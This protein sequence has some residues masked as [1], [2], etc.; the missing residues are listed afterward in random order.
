LIAAPR[1]QLALLSCCIVL[2]AACSS[3]PRTPTSDTGR[4]SPLPASSERDGPPLNP[5]ADIALTPDA[6]PQI[7]PIRA[8]GPNKPYEVQGERYTPLTEDKPITQSGLASWYGR[9]FHGRPTA[10][11]ELYSMYA[12]TAAHRTLPIPS[13]AR[14]RNPK[15]GKEVIVRVNDRGPFHSQR[16]VD[17]SYAAAAKLDILHGVSPV[18]IERITHEAIRSGAWRREGPTDTASTQSEPAAEPIPLQRDP[19]RTD[20]GRGWW[21]QLGAFGNHEAAL[22]L[23]REVAKDND[24]LS[25][26]LALFHEKGLHKLQA[27]PYVSRGEA[28]GALQRIRA[29]LAVKPVLV[30]RQ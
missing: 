30:S 10:S 3:T 19:V 5:P 11:G 6:Q 7:E 27:G 20:A 12:M 13:Y 1:L 15:N 2:L 29:A 17:L 14:I 28:L 4:T 23:Q 8:G 26:L 21:V 22:S 18:E 24:W 9:K 25:P 16:V